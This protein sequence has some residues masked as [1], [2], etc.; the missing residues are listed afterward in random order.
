MVYFTDFKIIFQG[1]VF[2]YCITYILL[3]LLLVLFDGELDW[4]RRGDLGFL[5]LD[6]KQKYW[7][8]SLGTVGFFTFQ[9]LFS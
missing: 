1:E 9:E 6:L 5:R 3:L 8:Q 7:W 2:C 4:G